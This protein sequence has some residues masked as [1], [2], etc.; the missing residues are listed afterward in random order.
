MVERTTRV[1]KVNYDAEMRL[2]DGRACDDCAHS[3]R[4]FALGFSKTGRTSCDFWPNLFRER[5]RRPDDGA[6]VREDNDW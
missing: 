4:C 1:A 5:A 6:L 3:R 2:P